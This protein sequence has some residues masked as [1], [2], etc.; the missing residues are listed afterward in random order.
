MHMLSNVVCIT[1][2]PM[3][4]PLSPLPTVSI[5][6]RQLSIKSD[7]QLMAC[8]HGSEHQLRFR[9]CDP[10]KISEHSACSESEIVEIIHS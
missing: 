1:V 7:A 8:M 2:P 10:G 4:S 5:A 6:V 3:V 9:G